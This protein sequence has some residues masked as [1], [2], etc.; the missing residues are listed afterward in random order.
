M[1]RP[2]SR[3]PRWLTVALASLAAA[4]LLVYPQVLGGLEGWQRIVALVLAA[5]FAALAIGLPQL[6]QWQAQQAAR[7]DMWLEARIGGRDGLCV[8]SYGDGDAVIAGLIEAE[9]RACLESLWQAQAPAPP[10]GHSQRR[11]FDLDALREGDQDGPDPLAGVTMGDLKRLGERKEAGETLTEAEELILS[12]HR[13]S[14]RKLVERLPPLTNPMAPML[15][16]A[17]RRTPEQYE[18]Q[19]ES[20]L[21]RFEQ[22]LNERLRWGYLREGLGRL[23]ITA[24]NPTDRTF[25]SVEVALHLSGKVTA[26]DP[27]DVSPPMP[28]LPGRPRAFGERI[29][30]DLGLDRLSR[31]S[32]PYVPP[33]VTFPSGPE[34]DN[35]ASARIKFDTVTLRPG[36]RDAELDIVHL[37]VTEPPG[38]TIEGTWEATATNADGRVSGSFTIPVGDRPLPVQRLL[39]RAAADLDDD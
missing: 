11:V 39:A 30:F 26:R 2:L 33:P 1:L 6:Q 28:T 13:D 25:E 32:F 37:I 7:L 24:I 3:I 21:K 8:P 38:S 12:S 20:H 9:R 17:D 29:P 19:V 10:T 14:M 36:A 23:S 18:E 22:A 34:I 5:T 4:A 15:S 31:T 35:S 16:E 27:D